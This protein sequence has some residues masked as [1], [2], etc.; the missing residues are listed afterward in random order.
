VVPGQV[1]AI[2]HWGHARCNCDPAFGAIYF[3]PNASIGVHG[4]REEGAAGC[5]IK[6]FICFFRLLAETGGECG[7][8]G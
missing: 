3:H 8:E 5:L 7:S 4:A 1:V 2:A 6:L